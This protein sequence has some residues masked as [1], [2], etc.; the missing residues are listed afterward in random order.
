MSITTCVTR[1]DQRQGATLSCATSDLR[2]KAL[3][4]ARRFV[5][6]RPADKR[7]LL[8]TKANR[9]GPGERNRTAAP[10]A[11]KRADIGAE[12][13]AGEVRYHEKDL[14]PHSA[15]LIQS[16]LSGSLHPSAALQGCSFVAVCLAAAAAAR[17]CGDTSVMCSPPNSAP[18]ATTATT[19]PP[20]RRPVS[21]CSRAVAQHLPQHPPPPNL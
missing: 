13:S 18:C 1:S 4:K 17:L 9:H 6:H 15:A 19:T 5:R 21:A 7:N 11:Q 12:T 3:S 2:R 16:P 14:L 10:P 20:P 8:S